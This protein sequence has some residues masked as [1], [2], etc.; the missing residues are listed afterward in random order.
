MCVE[1]RNQQVSAGSHL[2]G[3]PNTW[4]EGRSR[5]GS[6]QGAKL[7]QSTQ[8]LAPRSRENPGE[9]L[10]CSLRPRGRK[11]LKDAHIGDVQSLTQ[12]IRVRR[13]GIYVGQSI[14]AGSL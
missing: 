8:L 13:G 14:R 7:S 3:G 4:D 12:A 6:E 5:E 9:A 2:T 1:R 11:Q 10:T